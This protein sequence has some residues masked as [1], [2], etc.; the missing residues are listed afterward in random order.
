M[1]TE[2]MEQDLQDMLKYHDL[3]APVANL[4]YSTT[5]DG[6]FLP[7]EPS[8][9]GDAGINITALKF[10]KK[11]GSNTFMYDTGICVQPTK[12]F[13]TELIPR[14]SIIKSGYMLSNSVGIIDA[15]FTG[16]IK[17]V[18]TKVDP[19]AKEL[20]LPFTLCQLIPRRLYA[21]DTYR[22]KSLDES[23]RGGGEFGSTNQ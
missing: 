4:K 7:H 19:E 21:W 14:S 23:A 3:D 1:T 13:Y 5:I 22:V 2:E 15:S 12:G 11:I 18:L 20:E 10:V 17:I 6:A 9:A 16:S 8:M